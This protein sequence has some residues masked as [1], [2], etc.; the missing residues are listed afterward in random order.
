MISTAALAPEG[1]SYKMRRVVVKRGLQ[2]SG[3]GSKMVEFC[4]AYARKQGI[5]SI[6]CHALDSAVNFYLKN[7]WT[8]EGD[9]CSDDTITYLQMRKIL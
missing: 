1:D 8:P 6:Y 9:Y 3:I 7:G 2:G 5:F 4:E